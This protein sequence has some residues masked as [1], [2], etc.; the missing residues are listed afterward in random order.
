[1]NFSRLNPAF[2]KIGITKPPRMLSYK[3]FF[4]LSLADDQIIFAS[5]FLITL[6]LFQMQLGS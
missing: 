3:L 2:I 5:S 4:G 6:V 1:V